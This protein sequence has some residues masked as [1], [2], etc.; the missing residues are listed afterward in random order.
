MKYDGGVSAGKKQ[1]ENPFRIFDLA[2]WGRYRLCFSLSEFL[3]LERR[4][5]Y[6]KRMRND[7][8]HCCGQDQ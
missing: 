3:P 1:R 6:Q 5:I 4:S 2:Q 8:S 7:E